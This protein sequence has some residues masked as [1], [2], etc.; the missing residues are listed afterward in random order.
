MTRLSLASF[1]GVTLEICSRTTLTFRKSLCLLVVREVDNRV[2]FSPV[3]HPT[4]V[5]N[6]VAMV[7]RHAGRNCRCAPGESEL[8]FESRSGGDDSSELTFVRFAMYFCNTPEAERGKVA[9]ITRKVQLPQVVKRWQLSDA[10]QKVGTCAGHG[11]AR[12][13]LWLEAQKD[14]DVEGFREGVNGDSGLL[15]LKSLRTPAQVVVLGWLV[16]LRVLEVGRVAH[17]N[18]GGAI[19]RNGIL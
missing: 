19:G 11:F 9:S 18:I 14:I 6:L 13:G 12:L 10:G 17:T 3:E 1:E 7:A 8:A 5:V 15:C 16:E 4:I 2:D